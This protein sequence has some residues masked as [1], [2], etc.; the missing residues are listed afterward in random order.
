MLDYWDK[1]K[2]GRKRFNMIIEC[3]NPTEIA[4]SYKEICN[5]TLLEY[6]KNKLPL[7]GT[8]KQNDTGSYCYLK[9]EDDFIFELFPLIKEPGLSIPDYFPPKQD[10]RAHISIIYPEEMLP[11]KIN[12]DELE[13]SFSFEVTGFLRISV[14][15]KTFFALAVS[16][17]LLKQLRLKYNL[18]T[19]LNYRGLLV[20]FH[21]TIATSVQP[22][23][24]MHYL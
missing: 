7:Q 17:P 3:T 14:F 13:Q 8:L 12:M 18:S 22:V 11:E 15:N 2:K 6:A 4:F 9:I 1:A 23:S 5:P 16:S 24:I 10:T 20:P 19:Q 21:I